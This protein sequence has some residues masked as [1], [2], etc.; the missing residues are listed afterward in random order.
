MG[1][2]AQ[3]AHLRIVFGAQGIFGCGLRQHLGVLLGGSLLHLLRGHEL[4]QDRVIS[5]LHTLAGVGYG[6][7]APHTQHRS[8]RK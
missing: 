6:S 8:H 2:A 7:K 5:H 1:N 4:G 3:A